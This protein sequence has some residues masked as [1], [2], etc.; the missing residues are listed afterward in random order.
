MHYNMYY[1]QVI[2][3]VKAKMRLI[4]GVFSEP[5]APTGVLG[6]GPAELK[7]HAKFLG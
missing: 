6:K 5:V 7:K 3:W 1:L 4:P 2:R